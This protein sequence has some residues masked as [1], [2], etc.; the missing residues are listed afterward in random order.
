MCS[1]IFFQV[2]YFRELTPGAYTALPILLPA[3]VILLRHLRTR[4]N[5]SLTRQLRTALIAGMPLHVLIAPLLLFTGWVA[6]L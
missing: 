1:Y 2:V 4:R 5:S 3:A 6:G